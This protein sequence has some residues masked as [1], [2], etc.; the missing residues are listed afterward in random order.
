VEEDDNRREDVEE[1]DV[2]DASEALDTD[3]V[4]ED[5]NRGED[6][7]EEDVD[8]ASEALDTDAVWTAA[9]ST[10]LSQVRVSRVS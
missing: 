9:G 10:Q 3:A 2:D 6:V 7:E 1:E 8:D 5:N 4:E